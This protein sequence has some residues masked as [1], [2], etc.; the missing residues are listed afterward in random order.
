[1]GSGRWEAQ[2]CCTAI[3]LAKKIKQC[4]ENDGLKVLISNF[5][6]MLCNQLQE[7]E[8]KIQTKIKIEFSYLKGHATKKK[9]KF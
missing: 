7:A 5:L 4:S 3:G 1:M 9:L 2:Q 6:M 8:M